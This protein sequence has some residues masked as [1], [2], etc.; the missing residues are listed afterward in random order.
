MAQAALHLSISHQ[1]QNHLILNHRVFSSAHIALETDRDWS[2]SSCKMAT[3]SLQVSPLL[4]VPQEI[5]DR[6]WD[7]LYIKNSKQDPVIKTV[8]RADDTSHYPHMKGLIYLVN[9]QLC[10]EHGYRLK[11]KSS[12]VNQEF[13]ATQYPRFSSTQQMVSR[14][15]TYPGI[16][17]LTL[18][19]QPVFVEASI[20]V[21][22][23]IMHY[24]FLLRK[25]CPNPEEKTLLEVNITGEESQI[26]PEGSEEAASRFLST[27]VIDQVENCTMIIDVGNL[28]LVGKIKHRETMVY[29]RRVLLF[30][31]S[32]VMR[33][34]KA[35]KN[36]RKDSWMEYKL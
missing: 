13:I 23:W 35:L 18:I 28:I 4:T 5:R 27:H 9:R 11:L 30:E 14:R 29:F 10:D 33:A 24:V 32:I 12:Q 36:P 8:N 21:I 3:S 2:A 6:I 15:L 31:E 7:L 19:I 26:A 25:Y 16:A 20:S 34:L 22:T 17:K 1:Y